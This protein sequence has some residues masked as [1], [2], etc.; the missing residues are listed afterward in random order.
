MA[1]FGK[2]ED[3]DVGRVFDW[4][5]DYYDEEQSI[6]KD[7]PVPEISQTGLRVGEPWARVWHN[8]AMHNFS[9]YI[10]WLSGEYVEESD[11]TTDIDGAAIFTQVENREPVGYIHI[12]AQTRG[13]TTQDAADYWGDG[14]ASKWSVTTDTIGGVAVHV[15]EK[16]ADP[17]FV[18]VV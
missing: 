18:P 1:N 9:S 8:F 14:D 11:G 7:R 16:L 6:T 5:L 13:F 12:V 10:K 15:F 2:T 4:A 17:E 3:H